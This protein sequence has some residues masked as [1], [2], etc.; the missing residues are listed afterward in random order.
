MQQWCKAYVIAGFL[1]L[2]CAADTHGEFGFSDP[3][4]GPA[5]PAGA[6]GYPAR[7]V[8]LDVAPGFLTP[9]PGYGE[10]PFWWWSGDDLDVERMIGQIKEL[11]KKGI[12][13]VQVNYSHLDTSGWMTD[14]T[15]PKLFTEEWWQ[16]YS[17][18]SEQCGKLDMGIGLS[19]YTLDWPR[20]AHNLF[21]DLFYHKPELNAL[22]LQSGKKQRLKG[23]E[24]VTLACDGGTFAVR[25]YLLQ[26]GQPQRGGIDLTPMLKE[27]E[28][29]WSAPAGEWE[30]WSFR[31]VRKPGSLNP[32][33]A[34]A[35]DT[36]IR[37]FFQQFQDRNPGGSS[38]GLNYFFNDE[39]HIGLGKFAWNSDFMQEF[40][41]RKGYDLLEVLPAMWGEMGDVTP[42]VRL[43]YADVRMALMEERYFKPI[44]TWHATRG[45]I[46]ACDSG[47]RGT[48]PNEFG[49]YFRVTRWYT[50]PGHDTPGAKADLIKGKV[51]SSIANLYR[52][53]RV[54]LEGYHSMG[55]GA[56]PEDLMF[57]TRENYLYGCTLLNLHGLYY[58]TYGSHWEWAPPCYHFRMPYWAHMDVFLRYFDRLSFLMSQGH[59]CCD[60]AVLYP[61]APYEAEMDG[62]KARKTAFDLAARLMAAGINFDFIDNDSLA[63]AEVAQG[64]LLVKAANASYQ[65]LVFPA[66]DAVRRESIEKAAAFAVAGGEVCVIGALPAAS[67]HAGRNDPWLA[68]LNN[69]AFK[70]EQRLENAERAVAFIRDAFTQ[71]VRGVDCTVRA[72]HRKAGLRDIYMVMDAAPGAQVDFRCQ[73][74]V[75][76]WDPWSGKAEP[77]RVTGSSAT[78]TRV[79]LPL[80]GYEAQIVVFTPGKAHRNPSADTRPL[81]QMTLP[82]TWQVSFV[83]TMDNTYG[84]FRMPVTALNKIIGVEARVFEWARELQPAAAGAPATSSAKTAWQDQLHGY[85]VKFYVLGPVPVSVDTARLEGQLASLKKVDLAVPV[86]VEGVTLSWQPYE[87]SWQYGREG[88][89]GHQGYHG[90]KRT[91]TDDFISLGEPFNGLNEIRYKDTKE[92]GC[93]YLWTTVAAAEN[94]TASI[95]VSNAPPVDQ[96]HTS[97]V[98]TP[99]VLYVNGHRLSDL[100]APVAL[101]QGANPTLVRYDHAGRGHFV[102]RRVDRPL[103]TTR[104]PLAMRWLNDP[105]VLPFDVYAGGQ[106]AEWFRFLSAPG[107][108]AIQVQ[109]AG[110]VQAWINGEPMRTRGAGRF[111]AAQPI[112]EAAVVELRVVPQLG[113]SGGAVISEPVA[114]ETGTG[115]MALG[116]WSQN[117]ILRNYSGGLRY[118][119]TVT[120]TA[121]QSRGKVE[122]DLGRVAATAEVLVNNQKAGVLV[123]PPWRVDLSGLL[124][125]GQNTFEVLVYNTLANHYQTIPSRYRGQPTA[126]LLGPVRLLS[127]DWAS[128][129]PYTP[130]DP[131]VA[132]ARQER[133][134]PL[135]RSVKTVGGLQIAITGG[136]LA[137]F[138]KTIRLAKNVLRRPGLIQAVPGVP[139]HNGGGSGFAA[140]F[141]G[142][143]GNS[144]GTW[145]TENDGQTFVGMDESSTLEIAFS[146]E[147]A[148]GGVAIYSLRTYAGHHDTRASQNY[149]VYAATIEAPEKF[150]RI[151]DVDFNVSGN[152]NEV[153]IK[154]VK[155][156][157]L[158]KGAAR[159]RLVFH[160]GPSGFNVYREIAVFDL[161][162]KETDE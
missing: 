82:E 33:L 116:D 101:L 14:L 72:L 63:R 99:A 12:S 125:T 20:G 34:G 153:T 129:E 76:L 97:P 154:S 130:I 162:D 161:P 56:A 2:S 87:F 15:E 156:E 36:V 44:Y 49:D 5:A 62:E 43:D 124:Q 134:P 4:Q 143:A 6:V 128:G 96:S 42:K 68:A 102:M 115:M 70:A 107:T 136:P 80:E 94:L 52:R 1:I 38:K 39:L 7:G 8:D 61:V 86:K 59:H 16:I 114:V 64:R 69:K 122:L 121:D 29:N 120:L 13:G 109:A 58:S 57:A 9:P 19:T 83:P 132:A 155:G 100:T 78:T 158:V 18:I 10:V 85:G 105:G 139:S 138:D 135:K 41:Q 118:Q 22:E 151:A 48:Q 65:A 127:R 160:K 119:C 152:L 159:L 142:S 73:G 157:P 108:H 75:E 66:M 98:I 144:K 106:T 95:H 23:G 60:V 89:P 84:D 147:Q 131:S 148:P 45:M 27:G 112:S 71:D 31:S 111:E 46:F 11:H 25:A 91:I 35:G 37:G 104:Q 50:A 117:G 113:S 140:L 149:S 145:E 77:L 24:S 32:L 81:L 88:D 3:A 28:I 51:S 90:L 103:P 26:E 110:A 17:R 141:N 30:I 133:P 93:Y 79:E 150:T 21:Y 74:A 126:G 67:D 55:W 47:G 123:A 137:E 40:Q 92:G 53:P 54:W 146:P